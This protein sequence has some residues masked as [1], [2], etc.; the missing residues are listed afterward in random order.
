MPEKTL[1]TFSELR[2]AR[3]DASTNK[4]IVMSDPKSWS[5]TPIRLAFFLIGALDVL[6]P[7]DYSLTDQ[8]VLNAVLRLV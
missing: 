6:S 7:L 8:N 2:H 4:S 3:D 5:L 1:G